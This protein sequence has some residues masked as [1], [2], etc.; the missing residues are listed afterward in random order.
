MSA[1]T[2]TAQVADAVASANQALAEDNNAVDVDPRVGAA[3]VATGDA[4]L[5]IGTPSQGP[6]KTA[7]DDLTTVFDGDGADNTVLLQPTNTGLR[8]AIIIDSAEA[9]ERYTF[10]LGGAVTSLQT[11]TDG[12]VTAFD[13][14]GAQLATVAPPWAV[15]QDGAPVP[16]HYV[17][18]GTS[19][20]QVV[21]HRN[22]DYRY[23]IVADPWLWIDLIDKAE[24][25]HSK[26]GWTLR[27]TPTG[28]A[29]AQAGGYFPGAAAWNE[30]Y[31]KYKNVGRG[32]RY[33]LSSM[34]NQIICH[35]QLA[36]F[37]STWNLDEWRPATG[38]LP[39]VG[40][41]CNPDGIPGVWS[42]GGGGGSW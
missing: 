33:N 24:W 38:Y 1:D 3:S 11:N 40:A 27:V 16:T 9:P 20:V 18:D 19:L 42:S 36:A 21:E 6:G 30:L 37:K 8:A 35:M 5:T 34:R 12:S 10:D 32:I 17:V 14:N 7:S 23:G 31:D 4:E 39:T 26:L 13:I 29:R 41:L 2:S 25:S 15:D 22:G 28:W